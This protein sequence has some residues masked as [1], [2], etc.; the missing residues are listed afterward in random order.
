MKPKLTFLFLACGALA[1]SPAKLSAQEAEKP[2]APQGRPEGEGPRRERGDHRGPGDAVEGVPTPFI[3]VVTREL[4]PE[5]RSQTGLQDGY[6]LLVVEIMPDGPAKEAGLQ[7]HDV[8]VKLDDQK[9]INMEQL[10]VLVRSQKKEDEITLTIRRAGAEQQIKVKVGEKKMPPM[11][12]DNRERGFGFPLPRGGGFRYEPPKGQ[13]GDSWRERAEKFQ[14]EMRDYQRRL[15]EWTG[16]PRDRPMPQPPQGGLDAPPRDGDGRRGPPPPGA[17]GRPPHG[18]DRPKTEQRAESS[19]RVESTTG[20]E[21]SVTM[22]GNVIR[23]DDTGVYTIRRDNDKAT[24][25]VRTKDGK[26]TSWPVNN[27]QE[28]QAVPKE[29]RDV[30]NEMDKIQF[31]GHDAGSRR[32]ELQEAP[33]P[34]VDGSKDNPPKPGGL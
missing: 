7:Q 33:Q 10:Q 9:L 12:T 24:F 8:L 2:A 15:Q 1:V 31:D 22:H 16:G 5:V 27:E 34:K 18:G 19:V 17:A 14:N 26:E 29:Y 3:G 11:R 23:T 25:T 6:G 30:L 4:E 21:N 32:R 28:R 20:G 13:D